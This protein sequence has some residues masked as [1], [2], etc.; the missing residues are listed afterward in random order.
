MTPRRRRGPIEL[1]VRRL[2][3]EVAADPVPGHE[4]YAAQAEKLARVLDEAG[5]GFLAVAAVNRELRELVK[6]MTTVAPRPGE[7]GG[8]DPRTAK[9]L[10]ELSAPLGDAPH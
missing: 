2:V 7:G 8:V 6:A 3:T 9:L 5:P 4:V 10:A 1:T